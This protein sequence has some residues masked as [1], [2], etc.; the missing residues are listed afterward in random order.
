MPAGRPSKF[1]GIDQVQLKKLVQKGFTDKELSDFFN[2]TEQTLNNFKKKHPEFFESLKDWKKEADRKV[3]MSLFERACGYSHPEDKIFT[4]QG[5]EIIVPTTKH[6][7][8]DPVAAIFWLKNRQ[9]DV[10]RDK[11]DGI[12]PNDP[13]KIEV[14]R[15]KR[16]NDSDRTS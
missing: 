15:V 6:Y 8:P 3:E 2:I 10:W 4:F 7:P 11:P 13:I 5:A 14:V 1:D 16:A 12:T 9:P